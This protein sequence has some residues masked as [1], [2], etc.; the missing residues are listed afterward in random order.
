MERE[1]NNPQPV[2]SL[3]HYKKAIS[4]DGNCFCFS[5]QAKRIMTLNRNV[6]N[7]FYRRN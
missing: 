2:G 1:N 7:W 3:N 6:M 5:R 4:V